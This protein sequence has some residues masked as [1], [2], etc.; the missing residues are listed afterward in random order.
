MKDYKEIA[1][2]VLSRRDKYEEAKKIKKQNIAQ[3]SAAVV[4]LIVI[5]ALS[6]GMVRRNWLKAQFNELLSFQTD[7]SSPTSKTTNATTGTSTG[8]KPLTP[9]TT[10]TTQQSNTTTSPVLYD[11]W[12]SRSMPGKFCTLSL[13]N[14]QNLNAIIEE[15]AQSN[16]KNYVYPFGYREERATTRITSLIVTDM[17]IEGLAPDGTTHTV[18][19][20]IYSL[21]GLSE[22]LALGVKFKDDDRIYTYVCN[23]YIPGTL[24]EFLEAI[25]YDN[26]VSYGGIYLPT[27]TFPINSENAADIKNYLFSDKSISNVMNADGEATGECIVTSIHCH[28]LGMNGNHLYIHESG[29]ITTNLIGYEYSFFVGK[30]AVADFLENSY[31]ITFEQIKQLTGTTQPMTTTPTTIPSTATTA[32]TSETE[33]SATTPTETEPTTEPIDSDTS[34]AATVAEEPSVTSDITTTNLS[35]YTSEEV[36]TISLPVPVTPVSE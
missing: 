13:N 2:R 19:V 1:K 12:E 4:S 29:H 16:M 36:T 18:L 31:N 8:K 34:E 33:T 20:D 22:E 11:D 35:E 5:S 7:V 28:E 32:I 6:F 3:I 15:G 24:G 10:P 27:G 17:P 21:R 9:T 30:D 14:M 25:D 26:T 23:S